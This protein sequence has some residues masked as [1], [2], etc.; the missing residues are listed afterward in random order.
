MGDFPQSDQDFYSSGFYVDDQGQT[1][2]YTYDPWDGTHLEYPQQGAENTLP[3]LPD[4][5][6]ATGQT[7][8]PPWGETGTLGGSDGD[9]YE[10]EPPLLEELGINFDHIWQK[11]LTVL[12][13]LKAADGSIMSET[14]LTGPVLFCVALGANL[15][16]AGKVHFGYIYGISGMSCVG[17]YLLLNMMSV[18]AVSCGCVA[19]I[20]GYCL[21][22]MVVLSAIAV[23]VS[24]QGY[25]GSLLALLVVGWCSMSASKIFISTLAMEDQQLLV[26]YPCALLYGVFA[27][28]TV[29]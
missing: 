4:P 5:C 27:L 26:A 22:P 13:P 1:G 8:Q 12:N 9:Y 25:L 17:L 29:F 16:M 15:L 7:H 24:L 19:S 10:E 14:D 23:L 28:L 18:L 20:L 3:G 11:T 21:L 2:A 6:L